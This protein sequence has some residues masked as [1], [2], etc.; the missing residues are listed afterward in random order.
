MSLI[1][2]LAGCTQTTDTN[3]KLSDISDNSHEVTVANTQIIQEKKTSVPIFM[4]HYIRNSDKTKD[5]LGY[6]LSTDPIKFE[7]LLKYFHD[8]GYK[9]IHVQ[10][11]LEGKANKK[12]IILTFDDGYEDFYTTAYPLLKKYGYTASVA[13]I[14]GKI[15]KDQF[16]TLAQ[17][18]EMHKDGFEILSHTVNHINLKTATIAIQQSELEKSKTDL[19]KVIGEPIDG[20]V[21]PSGKYNPDTISILK[22]D[23]YKIALT[24]HPGIASLDQDLF[25]LPRIR[26]DNRTNIS[27]LKN[28]LSKWI[29]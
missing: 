6:N 7:K 10:D 5:L 21:Y 20:F 16:M 19:E 24:T 13:V 25:T 17:I 12:D 3:V 14:T 23:R 9:T 28:H 27:F 15:N 2:L 11:F 8:N 4:F 26:V 18:K 29:Q 22:E 1:T